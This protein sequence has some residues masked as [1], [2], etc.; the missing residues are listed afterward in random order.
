MIDKNEEQ[1]AMW[2]TFD[3]LII[4]RES[5]CLNDEVDEFIIDKIK[6]TLIDLNWN[7]SKASKKLGLK[8]TTLL[9]KCKKYNLLPK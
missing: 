7:Q 4:E 8:R 6:D 5:V 9:S 1:D 3:E 2:N